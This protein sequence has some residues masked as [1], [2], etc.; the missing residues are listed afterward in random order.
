VSV[1]S[2]PSTAARVT[3]TAARGSRNGLIF[4]R[5][6]VRNADGS[7]YSI[8]IILD[9][10]TDVHFLDGFISFIK[11]NASKSLPRLSHFFY[12]NTNNNS[13]NNMSDDIPT[14]SPGSPLR[15]FVAAHFGP[16]DG[17]MHLRGDATINN[18]GD[19]D[20][21][22]SR[23]NNNLG[24][25]P[26]DG[27][28]IDLTSSE[29]DD[30]SLISGADDIFT[31][32]TQSA[33]GATRQSSGENTSASSQQRNCF[34][35]T[36][37]DCSGGTPALD[38]SLFSNSDWP[39]SYKVKSL[40]GQ[41]ERCPTTDRIHF[42]ILVRFSRACRWSTVAN[43]FE[44]LMGVRCDVKW[45]KP[46][47]QYKTFKYVTKE[48]TR[49]EEHLHLNFILNPPKSTGVARGRPPSTENRV[50]GHRKKKTKAQVFM[51][52]IEGH[53]DK[54]WWELY[55]HEDTTLE[56]RTGMME[57]NAL[58]HT[59]D[60]MRL[61]VADNKIETV[62]ILYG[63]AGTGKTT[64]ATTMFP[65]LKYY[66]KD[67]TSGRWFDGIT[68]Q[69]EVLIIEE[70]DGTNVTI[71]TLLQLTDIGKSPPRVE[72]KSS[73]VMGNWKHV[74]ITS[75]RHPMTWYESTFLREPVRWK[76]LARR[77]TSCIY[78]PLIRDDGTNNIYG[79]GEVQC[80]PEVLLEMEANMAYMGIAKGKT[81]MNLTND[82]NFQH[83][84]NLMN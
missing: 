41:Y 43:Y 60:N 65:G 6:G 28:S 66:I 20:A 57:R 15:R 80:E 78:Y 16:H 38:N 46:L 14:Q 42:H 12:H 68:R 39:N 29:M 5:R 18:N 53:K 10:T 83:Y 45:I 56:Q 35:V 77:V 8:I 7:P 74:I 3:P 36:C 70:M 40:C 4:V 32:G 1:R 58:R 26:N 84:V 33:T 24:G 55:H 79:D 67:S 59:W 19:A 34:M 48:E 30:V 44:H 69:D 50:A 64:K 47:D 61:S 81:N 63:A 22:A 37:S 2:P 52:W 75:N 72:V 27:F 76:A 17:G 31:L 13:N 51:E 73:S 82:N 9:D 62:T 21:D 11:Y 71:R 23:T 49:S 25:T 54:S